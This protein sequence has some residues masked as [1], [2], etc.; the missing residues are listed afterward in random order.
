[1]ENTT[2]ISPYDQS[3]CRIRTTFSMPE[4]MATNIGHELTERVKMSQKKR[5]DLRNE[6]GHPDG[7]A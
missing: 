7:R 3:G 4:C 6:A 2:Y 1:M 5:W